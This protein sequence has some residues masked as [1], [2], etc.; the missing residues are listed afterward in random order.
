MKLE[1]IPKIRERLQALYSEFETARSE[2]ISRIKSIERISG[3]HTE[4]AR[5]R[6]DGDWNRARENY[7]IGLEKLQNE[8]FGTDIPQVDT[9]CVLD[10]IEHFLKAEK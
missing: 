7:D 8:L 10:W 9:D 2:H 3:K 1:D 6:I 4:T 5:R